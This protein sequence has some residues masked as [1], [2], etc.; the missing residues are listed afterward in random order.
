MTAKKKKLARRGARQAPYGYTV[1]AQ[2]QLTEKPDEMQIIREHI[3][4]H[5]EFFTPGQIAGILNDEGIP[6]KRGG[7]WYAD[8]VKRVIGSFS[9]QLKA[10]ADY[11]FMQCYRAFRKR[12]DR[13]EKISEYEDPL[14]HYEATLL[15]AM[16]AWG[17]LRITKEFWQK[18]RDEGF[19]QIV[20]DSRP[21]KKERTKKEQKFGRALPQTYTADDLFDK[22]KELI[23]FLDLTFDEYVQQQIDNERRRTEE[24]RDRP[25]EFWSYTDPVRDYVL[26]T[27]GDKRVLADDI[28][29]LLAEATGRDVRT[30]LKALAEEGLSPALR[31]DL[32]N[33]LNR[34]L[35]EIAGLYQENAYLR[36]ALQRCRPDYDKRGGVRRPLN[37]IA[38]IRAR[39]LSDLRNRDNRQ[40]GYQDR[41]PLKGIDPDFSDEPHFSE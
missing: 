41:Y 27:L 13:A 2:G 32:T 28:C 26:S 31:R 18:L 17:P 12:K 7:K 25:V 1:D 37:I 40:G 14:E 15:L 19:V 33:S 5:V 29:R 6:S 39:Q 30:T 9:D 4:P 24:R 16:E 36:Q 21:S 11:E 8:T 20:D 34:L 10:E 22:Y 38:D 3:V 23:T 35:K